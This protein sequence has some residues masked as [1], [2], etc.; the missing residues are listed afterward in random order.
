MTVGSVIDEAYF[1]LSF[2]FGQ[3]G[4]RLIRELGCEDAEI[5]VDPE[6]IKRVFVNIFK[7]SLQVMKDGGELTVKGQIRDNLAHIMVSDTG[8]GISEQDLEKI[9]DPFFTTK[10]KGVGLGLSIVKKIV[11]GNDGEIAV[12]SVL[13]E[14]T[15]FTI[16]LPLSQEMEAA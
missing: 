6:Q 9:F 13:G 2:E 1:L 3:S 15:I 10:E 4:A 5:F 7:N 8:P 12:E 14:F 11:E 16:S